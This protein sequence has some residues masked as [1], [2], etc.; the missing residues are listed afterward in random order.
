MPMI[1]RSLVHQAR[2][3]ITGANVHEVETW[4]LCYELSKPRSAE[5]EHYKTILKEF[6]TTERVRIIRQK[7]GR[8]PS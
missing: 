2:K 3:S 5:R 8:M 4:I 6:V 7:G 1:D